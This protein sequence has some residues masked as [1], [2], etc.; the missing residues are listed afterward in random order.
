MAAQKG[1]AKFVGTSGRSYYKQFYLSDVAG[2][3]TTWDAG[4]GAG[5]S[6]PLH[7]ILPEPAVLVDVILA[8]ATGQ[9]QTQ[10][11]RDNVPTGDMLLNAVHLASITFR[12]GVSIPFAR[13]Q[14]ISMVQ[15]A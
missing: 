14:Q 3:L 11:M 15:I 7:T 12:P 5:A 6:S 10:I 4:N 1:T 8:A 9:T 2:A 13:G